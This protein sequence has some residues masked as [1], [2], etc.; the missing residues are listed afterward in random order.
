MSA[1]SDSTDRDRPQLRLVKGSGGDELSL[2][3]FDGLFR[4]F[5]PYVARIGY[6]LMGGDADLD[7]L[8]QDV[9]LEAHRRLHQVRDARAVKAW[10]ACVTVRMATRRLKRQR[11]KFWSSLEGMGEFF[12][13]ADP[14]ASPEQ[15]AEVASV[16]RALKRFPVDVRVAWVLRYVEGHSLD[17]IVE[18][19]GASKSTVQRR[20]RTGQ[21]HLNRGD[22]R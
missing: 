4:R 18:L 5:A 1:L 17:E 19:T 2:D 13:L 21:A 3:D 16:Y 8:V 22:E 14:N 9:F 11:L 10:L 20:I 6:R 12:D 15:R 7:D